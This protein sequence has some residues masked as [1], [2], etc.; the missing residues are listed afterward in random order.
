MMPDA[1]WSALG[2]GR[3]Q[4]AVNRLDL[5]SGGNPRTGLEDNIFRAKGVL[6]T[7]NAELVKMA[8]DLAATTAAGRRHPTR[9]GV[10]SV[11]VR[12]RP[13]SERSSG[14]ARPS[15]D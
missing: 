11:S 14:S 3:H 15:H 4:L 13:P 7:S 2:T 9:R 10:S 8:A 12:R 6:A 1:T 5:A